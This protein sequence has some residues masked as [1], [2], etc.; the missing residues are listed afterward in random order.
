MNDCKTCANYIKTRPSYIPVFETKSNEIVFSFYTDKERYLF[1]K[2]I[3]KI[4]NCYRSVYLECSFLKIATINGQKL[5]E[6]DVGYLRG[7]KD[8]IQMTS[9]IIKDTLG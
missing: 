7:L 8:G 6:E 5:K 3:K 4:F 2:I 9:S 1:E